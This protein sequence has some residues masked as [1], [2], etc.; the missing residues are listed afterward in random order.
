MVEAEEEYH[1]RNLSSETEASWIRVTYHARSLRKVVQRGAN[2]HVP[3]IPHRSVHSR[4]TI[5]I[6]FWL[7][8]FRR[9]LCDV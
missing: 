6:L 8:S 4:L 9:R 3:Q 7:L 2:L 5:S 1:Y